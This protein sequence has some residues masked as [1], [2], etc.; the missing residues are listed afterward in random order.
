[1]ISRVF[2]FQRIWNVFEGSYREAVF[3]FALVYLRVFRSVILWGRVLVI[4][5]A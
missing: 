2:C 1:L 5:R 3:I 4:A